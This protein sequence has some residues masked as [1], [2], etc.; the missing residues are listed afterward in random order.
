MIFNSVMA[1]SLL[2]IEGKI[3]APRN[4]HRR[5]RPQPSIS[6]RGSAKL[7]SPQVHR[8]NRYGSLLPTRIFVDWRCR[9]VT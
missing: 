6:G 4:R 1:P 8:V 3:N 7:G 5:N 9:V 2:Q